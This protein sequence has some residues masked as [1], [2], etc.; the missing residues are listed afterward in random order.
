MKITEIKPQKRLP[1]RVSVFVDG[2]YR[3]SLDQNTL[4]HA[5]LHVGDEIQEELIEELD[6]KDQF[7]RARDYGYLL[8]SYRD[9]T[10]REMR[11]RLERKGFAPDTVREVLDFFRRG[12]MVDDEQF[13]RN[14]VS[15]SL[16]TRPM[17]RLRILHELR[18]RRVGDEAA[19][20]AV[21]EAFT[22]DAGQA[23]DRERELAGRAADKRMKTLASQDP[24][25]AR[26]RLYRHLKSR[27]FHFAVIHDVVKERFS[28]HLH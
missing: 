27:G 17:G 10:E 24:E 2:R 21:E 19:E 22:A 16:R 13:A 14:W 18:R 15:D 12:G 3:F 28:D 26:R 4:Y 6:L 1:N 20:R 7:P 11:D 8:L 25:T 5:G 9:R 23:Q